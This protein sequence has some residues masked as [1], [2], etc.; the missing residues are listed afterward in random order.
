MKS[1]KVITRAKCA[2]VFDWDGVIFNSD[3]LKKVQRQALQKFRYSKIFL[4]KTSLASAKL[5]GGYNPTVHVRL[6]AKHTDADAGQLA[7]RMYQ[8][9]E[10]H[11]SDFIFT[12]ATRILAVLKDTKCAMDILTSGNHEFQEYKIERSKLG[13]FFRQ[14]HMVRADE[15]IPARKLRVLKKLAQSHGSLIF[16]D[17]R[18]DTIDMVRGEPSLHGKVLPILVWRHKSAPP[19][20]LARAAG[21]RNM[22]R[23]LNWKEIQKIAIRHGFQAY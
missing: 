23:R 3:A 18:A 11:P 16:L 14:V 2:I 6:I 1:N 21:P 12:D 4:E 22:V 19:K 10:K 5:S 9:I 7:E 17:D 15:S 20:S 8:A 13:G